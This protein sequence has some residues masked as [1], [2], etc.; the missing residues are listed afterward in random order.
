MIE[1]DEELINTGPH[2]V[3]VNNAIFCYSEKIRGLYDE[4][5]AL[6]HLAYYE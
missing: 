2:D 5:A 3:V 4:V 6:P 1:T